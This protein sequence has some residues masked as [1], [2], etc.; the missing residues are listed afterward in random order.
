M[1]DGQ[2]SKNLRCAFI[3]MSTE[4]VFSKSA[5]AAGFQAR[6]STTQRPAM[7]SRNTGVGKRI[8]DGRCAAKLGTGTVIVVVLGARETLLSNSW[9]HS[10]TPGRV[11]SR[12]GHW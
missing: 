9:Q 8:M 6:R 11:S 4:R 12:Q 10:G 7:R 5:K 1:S 3:R 2:G